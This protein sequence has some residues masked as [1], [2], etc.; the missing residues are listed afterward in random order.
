M[1]VGSLLE[2]RSLSARPEHRTEISIWVDGDEDPPGWKLL[3]FISAH[4][5]L[6]F[7]SFLWFVA[8]TCLKL[9]LEECASLF[10]GLPYHQY[11][12]SSDSELVSAQ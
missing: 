1:Q 11:T 6:W 4:F 5:F 7:V 3:K 12:A 2:V 9:L 10:K 8:D